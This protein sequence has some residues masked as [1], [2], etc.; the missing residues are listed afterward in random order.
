MSYNET[1]LTIGVAAFVVYTTFSVLYFLEMHRTGSAL[2]RVILRAEEH[3]LPTFA[4]A[5]R[6]FEE[7][8]TNRQ[9]SGAFPEP[10]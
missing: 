8:E 1:L 3:L 6:I 4:A 2:R 7:V 9:C 10:A 5:R